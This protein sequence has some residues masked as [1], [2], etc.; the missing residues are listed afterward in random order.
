MR[1][2]K[3]QTLPSS[4]VKKPNIWIFGLLTVG[5]IGT[6]TTVY[7]KTQETTPEQDLTSQTVPVQ[8]KDWVVQIQ[9]SG[10]VQAVQKINLSPE[11]SGRIAQL[12]INEGSRV[13]KGQIIARMSSD[14]IQAQVNQYQ[15]LVAKAKAD[16]AQKRAGTR[17]EEIAEQKAKVVTAQASIAAAQARLNRATEELNLNQ[18]LVR[19]GALSRNSFEEFDAKQRD[20]KAN[21]QA[22]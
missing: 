14:R 7:L 22:E 19:E 9:A 13:Q 1:A 16:L 5:L 4:R 15:A 17:I 11:E 6:A 18:M 21:L 20:A 3:T 8:T 2:I 12:Y 10:V